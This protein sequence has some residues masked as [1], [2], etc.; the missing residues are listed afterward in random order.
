NN[1]GLVDLGGAA[2]GQ[3]LTVPDVE[4]NGVG[5]GQVLMA[6]NFAGAG[7]TSCAAATVADCLSLPGATTSGVTRV[8]VNA[9]GGV[10]FATGADIVLVDVAGGDSAAGHFILDETSTGYSDDAV[11]NGIVS[12]DG[13]LGYAL[14]YDE[15]TQRHY[16]SSVM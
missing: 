4:W 11:Y 8:A 15:Q 3:V 7:Q 14:I 2:V 6:V 1:D 13:V 12:G 10:G 16:L 5:D 9:V